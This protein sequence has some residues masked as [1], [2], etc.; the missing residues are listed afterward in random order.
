MTR[1]DFAGHA[2]LP[3]SE[4]GA[5]LIELSQVFAKHA[6]EGNWSLDPSTSAVEPDEVRA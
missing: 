6:G 2:V 1:L 3:D 5:L 4:V